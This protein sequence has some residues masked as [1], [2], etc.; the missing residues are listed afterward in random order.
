M[1]YQVFLLFST[2]SFL[3]FFFEHP[4][5][6]LRNRFFILNSRCHIRSHESTALRIS[7]ATPSH[8]FA[9]LSQLLHYSLAT[10]SQ[11]FRNYIIHESKD[12]MKLYI[13]IYIYICIYMYILFL[14]IIYICI[15]YILWSIYIYNMY[16]SGK[17]IDFDV[18]CK[19]PL[20][21]LL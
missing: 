20:I 14:I 11:P 7:C 9:T 12:K 16:L 21:V 8:I 4:E 15:L 2:S 13:Y 10:L 17:S 5:H 6:V 1:I 19:G 3:F 18:V